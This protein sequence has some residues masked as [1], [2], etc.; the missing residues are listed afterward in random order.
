MRVPDAGIQPETNLPRR[1][2]V[3]PDSDATQKMSIAV[4]NPGGQV[5]LAWNQNIM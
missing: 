2:T 4:G 3:A 1:P 5:L